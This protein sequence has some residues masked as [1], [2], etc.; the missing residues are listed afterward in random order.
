MKKI[1]FITCCLASFLL[2][3]CSEDSND[4]D[5]FINEHYNGTF[6]EKW[7]I[8]SYPPDSFFDE[9]LQYVPYTV[10]EVGEA[11]PI[12]MGTNG[13]SAET[14]YDLTIRK[15]DAVMTIQWKTEE[16]E[17]FIH[18]KTVKY[19]YEAGVYMGGMIVVNSDAIIVNGKKYTELTDFS[20]LRQIGYGE[21]YTEAKTETKGYKGVFSIRRYGNFVE[22]KNDDYT[23]EI[24]Y[25]S[26]GC[27]LTRI[28]PDKEYI[29]TLDRL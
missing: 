25:V 14:T 3:A 18:S 21:E 12:S 27:D 24:E 1:I 19:T 11:D 13:K 5:N 29:G 2:S 26:G 15:S 7:P 22:F 6:M 4:N 9:I 28:S 10:E 17:T 20:E 23:Y 8:T 16:G